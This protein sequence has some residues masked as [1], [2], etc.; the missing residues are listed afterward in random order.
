M[1]PVSVA[2]SGSL[3]I[4]SCAPGWTEWDYATATGPYRHL[5]A[6]LVGLSDE[7]DGTEILVF[8]IVKEEAA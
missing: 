6:R 1:E 8:D 5:D 7:E 2:V 3:M 4:V